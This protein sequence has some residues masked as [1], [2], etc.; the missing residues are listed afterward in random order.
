M[1]IPL[2]SPD[3]TDKERRAVLAVLK[4]NT[5]SLGPRAKEFEEKIARLAQ[6]KYSVSL[7]SGTAA[8]HLIVRSLGIGKG[9]EIITTPF[10]FIASSN[11]VLF[12]EAKPVFVD[13][14]EKTLCIDPT[15]IEKAITPRTKAILGVDVFGYPADW[16]AILKIA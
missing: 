14:D 4:T 16:D 3:I 1:K 5:L 10:S 15:K 2:S 7:N 11:C 8:L 13:I 6:R 9:D 12:E